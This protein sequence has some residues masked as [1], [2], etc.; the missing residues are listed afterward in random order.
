MIDEQKVIKCLDKESINLPM[1]L[2]FWQEQTK[3]WREEMDYLLSRGQLLI[4]TAEHYRDS[5]QMS[6]IISSLLK[7]SLK[8]EAT[9][10][11]PEE[12]QSE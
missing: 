2:K 11:K 12:E 1:H 10:T 7:F 9:D 4:G 8:T 6:M 5:L 3:F